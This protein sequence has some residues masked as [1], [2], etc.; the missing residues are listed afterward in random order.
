MRKAILL[1]SGLF[2]IGCSAK[3][4]F[5]GQASD[6]LYSAPDFQ[7]K[8]IKISKTIALD[9]KISEGSGL[10]VWH[11]H[12]WAVNDSGAPVLFAIDTL[13]G[14]IIN[15]YKVPVKVNEDW[16]E[17]SQDDNYF[18]IGA[19]GNNMNKKDSLKI[20]RVSK[21]ELIND[22]I[23]VD[24]I[25]FTWPVIVNNNKKQKIN[26]DCEAMVVI[27][28]Q[29]YLFTKEWK[30]QQCTKV[31]SLPKIPGTYTANYKTTLQTTILITGANYN[32]KNKNLVLC[33]HN[34]LA[35]PCLFVFPAVN[36]SD[37]FGSQAERILVKQLSFDQIEGVATFD[38]SDYYLISED[39]RILFVHSNQQLNKVRL[40]N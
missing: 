3:R 14:K 16:E 34:L 8:H 37:L 18:Y 27:E 40:G 20:Y 31:F 24:S 7:L 23:I 11:S 15:E 4:E 25:T 21:T 2:I 35:R 26:F 32:P 28:N 13:T 1:L 6:Q 36:T 12:L 9:P 30:Q 29:I 5:E 17:L 33:G 19:F 10:V 38:G 39:L 22:R